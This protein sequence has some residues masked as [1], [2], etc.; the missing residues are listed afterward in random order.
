MRGFQLDLVVLGRDRGSKSNNPGT[1]ARSNAEATDAQ[2]RKACAEGQGGAAA[3]LYYL[4]SL[5]AQAFV[6][7]KVHWGLHRAP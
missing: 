6:L 7:L 2:P 5:F 4:G 1:A 3:A